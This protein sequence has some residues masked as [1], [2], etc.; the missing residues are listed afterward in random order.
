MADR[1]DDD[2]PSGGG[3]FASYQ[4]SLELDTPEPPVS[5]DE[6]SAAP[7]GTM[8]PETGSPPTTPAASRSGAARRP[9][10][11]LSELAQAREPSRLPGKLILLV[12]LAGLGFGA[13]YVYCSW[14]VSGRHPTFDAKLTNL[15]QGL[16]YKGRRIERRDVHD[17]LKRFARE[18]ALEITSARVTM[19]PLDSVSSKK[20]NAIA[21]MAM[22]FAAKMKNHRAPKCVIEVEV[23][24]KGS[25][26]L[27]TKTFKSKRAT[28]FDHVAKGACV[29]GAQGEDR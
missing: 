4:G 15:R 20:L 28:W 8:A 26:G 3:G 12:V 1:H 2:E 6:R 25:Y 29:D 21:Q 23:E 27:V 18:S 17:V 9:R 24:L 13:Y 5:R 16:L 22:G 11:N 14:T 19:E 10:P 7:R